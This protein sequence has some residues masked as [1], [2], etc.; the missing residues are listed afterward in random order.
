MREHLSQWDFVTAA[1]AVVG[2]GMVALIG[3]TLYAMRSRTAPRRGKTPM[4][5][6]K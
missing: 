6:L 5:T 1:Y 4:T 2:I 3:W